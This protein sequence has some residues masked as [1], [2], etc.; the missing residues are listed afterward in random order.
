[1]FKKKWSTGETYSKSKRVDRNKNIYDDVQKMD[2]KQQPQKEWQKLMQ[3]QEPIDMRDTTEIVMRDNKKEETSE[4]MSQRHMIMAG[5]MN[6]YVKSDYLKDL[7]T[8]EEFLKPQR[9]DSN[10][11][12]TSTG[13][14]NKMK[15]L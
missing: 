9:H 1:M 13:V 3:S 4:R 8:Q 14:N 15:T 2:D 7:Q 6:P 5:T 11:F 10:A 12:L